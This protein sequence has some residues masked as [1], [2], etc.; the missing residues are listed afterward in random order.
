MKPLK[1]SN[2][3]I[4]DLC[5]ELALL[6]H[7]GVDLGDGLH[8]LTNEE[9]EKS[10][11]ELLGALAKDVESGTPLSLAFE[12]V[13]CFPHY[14]VGLLKVGEESGRL[15]DTLN[16][17]AAYY[18]ER[19]RTEHQVRSTLTYPAILLLL[20]LVVIVVL[21]SK[22]LPVF[23]EIYA[24]L[25]GELTGV[26][27]GLLIAGQALDSAMPVLCAVMAVVL[28]FF[29]VFSLH[30]GFRDRIMLLWHRYCGDRG[31]S[32]TMNNAKF[33]QALSM[34]FASGLPLDDAVNLAAQLL[35]DIPPAAARCSSCIELL[36]Q[37]ESLS[38]ALGTTELMSSASCRL[39]TLGMRSGTADDVMVDVARRMSE[40]SQQDLDRMIAKIEPTLVL[41]TS[42]LVGVILLSVMLPLMNIMTAIG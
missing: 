19:E 27:K 25:G 39:L 26:A 37:G 17:L 2:L 33:A 9:K 24:S 38:T 5:R 20:M 8:L 29:A 41:I 42:V 22:V 14:V 13:Q 40:E 1:L 23:N 12:T 7:A 3:E 18:E 11:K 34:G 28:L 4:S 15:E 35:G 6:I 30:R 32:K 36:K 21:L 16:A 10:K 31:I